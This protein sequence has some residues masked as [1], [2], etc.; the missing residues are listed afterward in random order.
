LP[1]RLRALEVAEQER[2]EVLRA[3]DNAEQEGREVLRA[4]E[5]IEEQEKHHH[6]LRQKRKHEKKDK[7]RRRS[8]SMSRP[9][10]RSSM[11][12]VPPEMMQALV[13]MPAFQTEVAKQL[14]K[15]LRTPDAQMK[16]SRSRSRPRKSSRR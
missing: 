12:M 14:A 6:H 10:S 2:R 11:A 1:S 9:R 15:H 3:L 16:G 5:R 13:S 7:E 8:R 4:L